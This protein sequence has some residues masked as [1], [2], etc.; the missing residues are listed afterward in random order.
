MAQAD[1][2]RERVDASNGSLIGSYSKN[3][4]VTSTDSFAIVLDIDTR[5]IR[6]S[7]FSIFN[8]H[9][10]NSIDYDIWGNLN[11]NPITAL[12]GTADTDYD[13]GWVQIKT[14]TAQTAGAAPAV[15]T[16]SNPYTRVVVRIKATSSSNQGTV[17]IWHRGEN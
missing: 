11:S 17:R 15:E 4:D 13:N 7:I 12:T 16:L 14:T 9:G 5:G 2:T 1:Y 6:E 3:I 8:T 10:S